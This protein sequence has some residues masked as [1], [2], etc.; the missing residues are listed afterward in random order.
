VAKSWVEFA[1]TV[2]TVQDDE[3]KADRAK[4]MREEIISVKEGV[5][6]CVKCHAVSET[7]LADGK[8]KLEIEWQYKE[9]NDRPHSQ[10]S[11]TS[12]IEIMGNKSSCSNCH[13]LDGKAEYMASFKGFDATK[14]SSNFSSIKRKTCIQCHTE[15]QINQDCQ[16]C[17]IYHLNPGFKKKMVSAKR[18][19]PEIKK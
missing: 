18:Q 13:I 2:S 1:L 3:D 8:K 10:Y 17:H 4:A 16:S 9:V 7:T 14:W 5:G 19:M 12:H 15:S 6:S 11:H